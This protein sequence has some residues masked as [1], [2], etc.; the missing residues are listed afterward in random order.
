MTQV[1]CNVDIFCLY[2]DQLLSIFFI[3]QDFLGY[4]VFI[5]HVLTYLFKQYE[6]SLTQTKF[7]KKKSII[8]HVKNS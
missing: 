6:L 2:F 7:I 1:N 5:K 8:Y 3:I 4:L